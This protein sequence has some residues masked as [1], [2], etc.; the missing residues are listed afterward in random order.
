MFQNTENRLALKWN[1]KA[2][3]M[4]QLN[5]LH[6][7]RKKSV[8]TTLIYYI[9]LSPALSASSNWIPHEM[10]KEK[11]ILMTVHPN[12]GLHQTQTRLGTP[13]QE[14]LEV[15]AESEREGDAI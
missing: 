2:G 7:L 15:F 5:L 9:A 8:S 3:E 1:L 4:A 6:F 13:K 10:H 14:V 11:P 12:P